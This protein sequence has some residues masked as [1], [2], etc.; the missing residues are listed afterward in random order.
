MSSPRIE[1]PDLPEYMT[2]EELERLPDE[3]A[4]QIE[5]WDGRVVW[6]RRG[7]REHQKFTRRLVNEIERCSRVDMSTRPERRW[8]VESETNVFLG[9]SGKS[10][11]LTPD[12]LV[13]RCIPSYQ[14]VRAADTVLVGEVLSPANTQTDIEA[15]KSR[16]AAAGIVWYWE[17]TLQRDVSAIAKIRAYGLETG[18]ATLPE[19]VRPLHRSDYR[20]VGE[21]AHAD[22][23]GVKFGYPFPI[24]I[25]WDSLAF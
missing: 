10:N 16:Y 17:V 12:F 9:A 15:K 23:A 11:F 24:E 7:P 2:W 4:E 6:V 25:L 22:E 1:K 14:D 19:G 3:I 13:H 20:L 21:W 8:E 18:V 5:L